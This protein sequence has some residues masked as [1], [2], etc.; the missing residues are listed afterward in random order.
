MS[1]P[2]GIATTRYTDR[3]LAAVGACGNAMPEFAVHDGVCYGG[4]LF[5][6][7]ALIAQEL[8][9]TKEVYDIPQSHYDGLDSVIPTLA[10]MALARIKNPE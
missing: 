6:L 8:F 10:F 3:T 7:P 9:N 4:I 5:L 1:A 2:L